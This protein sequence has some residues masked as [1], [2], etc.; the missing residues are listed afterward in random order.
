M[1]PKFFIEASECFRIW[2]ALQRTVPPV[3][4]LI[5]YVNS[6]HMESEILEVVKTV[7]WSGQKLDWV[8][9]IFC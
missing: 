1:I 8:I 3:A 9:S 2:K 6:I 7:F 4:I 5:H